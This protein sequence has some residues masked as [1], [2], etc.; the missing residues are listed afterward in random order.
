MPVRIRLAGVPLNWCNAVTRDNMSAFVRCVA[1]ASAFPVLVLVG[2]VQSEPGDPE[3][4]DTARDASAIRDASAS[5]LADAGGAQDLDAATEDVDCQ[6]LL[7]RTPGGDSK[8]N[9]FGVCSQLEND[10]DRVVSWRFRLEQ[11]YDDNADATQCVVDYMV[12]HGLE[13]SGSNGSI[14]AIGAYS[15]GKP[16]MDLDAVESVSVSCAEP[17][18]EN[19]RTL[20]PTDCSQDVLCYVLF[21]RRITEDGACSD[22][23]EPVGCNRGDG[24]CG[25]VVTY[26]QGPDGT[27]WEFS[28]NCIP[29]NWDE[30]S[31]DPSSCRK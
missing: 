31:C 16:L 20:S 5:A 14:R 28:D 6:A 17:D 25:S 11:L 1:L 2:C 4:P 10:P 15:V 12:E 29:P 7:T 9:R 19:C 13:A 21:A 26:A 3:P 27:C 30:D 22:E 18:C 8:C 24:E 23:A